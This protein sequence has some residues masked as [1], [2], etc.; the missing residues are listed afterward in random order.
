MPHVNKDQHGSCRTLLRCYSVQHINAGQR[1][2]PN[3][4]CDESDKSGKVVNYQA[5]FSLA[6]TNAITVATRDINVVVFFFFV[7]LSPYLRC[8]FCILATDS[9][10]F[11]TTGVLI[12][13]L[14]RS[15]PEAGQGSLVTCPIRYPFTN[16][17]GCSAFYHK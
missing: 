3:A 7:F 8:Y 12:G 14:L 11:L 6:A 9:V 1:I 5:I 16:H 15:A 10:T 2:S 17:Y 4:T 13:D